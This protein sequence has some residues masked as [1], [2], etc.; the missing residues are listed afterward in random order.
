[1]LTDKQK[2]ACFTGHRILPKKGIEKMLIKLNN[3]I[4][5]LIEQ[6]VTNF[7]SGGAIGFDQIAASLIIAKKQQGMNI[8]LYF[9]LPCID[10][11]KKWAQR[12]KEL[13]N[14]LLN[15]ADAV[16]YISKEYTDECMKKRN[17]YM[18][19]NSSYCIC[20]LK[21]KVSGTGQTVRYAEEMGL[22]IVNVA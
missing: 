2:T 8:A 9:I 6:G 5:R 22:R 4:D 18:V 14:N 1:M 17:Y 3:E 12:Q 13:Y 15:E 19:D 16:H 7:I 10:Q 21:Y 11:D 20:A